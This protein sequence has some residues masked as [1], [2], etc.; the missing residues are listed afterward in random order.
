MTLFIRVSND[1][2]TLVRESSDRLNR[3][4][5]LFLVTSTGLLHMLFLLRIDLLGHRHADY[6]FF[7]MYNIYW[8]TKSYNIYTKM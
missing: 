3:P 7:Q 6:M 4:L 2:L 8:F 5:V 1:Q